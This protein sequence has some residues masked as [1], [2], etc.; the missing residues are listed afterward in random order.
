MANLPE[1]ALEQDDANGRA[2]RGMR[3]GT[4]I[5]VAGRGRGRYAGWAKQTL[6]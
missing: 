6:S 4:V 3:V 5:F 2:D 1:A